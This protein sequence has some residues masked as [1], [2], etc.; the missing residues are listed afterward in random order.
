MLM[1]RKIC[2]LLLSGTLSVK[3]CITVLFLVTKDKTSSYDVTAED[4]LS[5]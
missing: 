4:M 1:V 3:E 2:L 5:V